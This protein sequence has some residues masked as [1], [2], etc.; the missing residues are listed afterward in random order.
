MVTAHEKIAVVFSYKLHSLKKYG[1]KRGQITLGV[2]EVG[3]IIE[4]GCSG[5]GI[6]AKLIW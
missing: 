6:D 2:I 4:I 3:V 5:D 1:N